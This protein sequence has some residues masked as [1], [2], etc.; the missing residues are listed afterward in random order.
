MKILRG[1][2]FIAWMVLHV[3]GLLLDRERKKLL[4]EREEIEKQSNRSE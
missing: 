3:Q 1:V 4:K 2:S